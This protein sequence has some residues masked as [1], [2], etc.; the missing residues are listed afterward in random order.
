MAR[1]K[2]NPL[3]KNRLAAQSNLKE[4]IV[5]TAK[6]ALAHRNSNKRFNHP[7]ITRGANI[8]KQSRPLRKDYS[9]P[10]K[11]DEVLQELA[12]IRK[13]GTELKKMK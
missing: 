5:P 11:A 10:R 8:A 3:D 13:V 2:I 12:A 4:T 7:N 6:P 1:K 9:S